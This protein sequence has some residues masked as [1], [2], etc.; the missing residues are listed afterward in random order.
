MK[1]ILNDI[2]FNSKSNEHTLG[3]LSTTP[4]VIQMKYV[5]P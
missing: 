5:Y 2:S 4:V 1:S 3:A